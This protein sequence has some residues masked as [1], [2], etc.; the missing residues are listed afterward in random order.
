MR[1][2]DRL[3]RGWTLGIKSLEV[4][5]SHPKLLLFP[6]L[7]GVALLLVLLSFGGAF[8]GLAG[9]NFDAMEAIFLKMEQLGE[10]VFYLIA[11]VFYFITYFIIVFFNVALVFN[12]RRIFTGETPSIRDGIAFSASRAPQIMAW[13]ALAATIGMVLQAIEEKVGSFVSGILGFAWSLATYFVIPTLA[14][15]EVGPIDALK[16]SSQTIKERWGESIG[17]GFSLGLFNLLGIVIA[18]ITG[19][20]L[21]FMIHPG[22]GV[23]LGILTF[24]LTL[25]VNGAA[26]NVFLTAA[27]E[28]THGN[29]PEAFD[30][31][32]LD[33]IFMAKK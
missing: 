1:F 17:A 14:A 28:H 29:T 25:V 2:F 10:V 7:S 13:A 26:R 20:L 6:V 12:V 5:G 33:G 24:M 4:I 22:V 11:F 30:S 32:T 31:E 16:K 15:E 8:L 23:A 18:I 27:Y 21:G 9:F 19:F 3:G